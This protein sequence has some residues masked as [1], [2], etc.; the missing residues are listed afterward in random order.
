[1]CKYVCVCVSVCVSVC[2]S[3]YVCLCVCLCVPFYNKQSIYLYMS[4]GELRP[5]S[6]FTWDYERFKGQSRLSG[7]FLDHNLACAEKD[8]GQMRSV[9]E[10]TRLWQ[11]IPISYSFR[12]IQ[13][14]LS[15][16]NNI[17][18][19][20]MGSR[21]AEV[22]KKTWKEMCTSHVKTRRWRASLGEDVRQLEREEP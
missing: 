21:G 4:K 16:T 1:M 12:N 11:S 6:T 10:R 22:S 17:Q 5:L 2:L 14:N 18:W 20:E 3:L 15:S 7:T 13:Q 9:A 19:A 8:R